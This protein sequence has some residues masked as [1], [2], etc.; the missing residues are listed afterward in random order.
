MS[1]GTRTRAIRVDDERWGRV[2]A[3]ADDYGITPSDVIRLLIDRH[4][5]KLGTPD[6]R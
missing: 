3:A 6:N 5:D 4:I 2:Q 1:K